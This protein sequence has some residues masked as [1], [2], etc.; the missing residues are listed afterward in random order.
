MKKDL[1]LLIG[2]G[3]LLGLA[4]ASRK[5]KASAAAPPSSPGAPG[6]APS[7][8]DD[9]E[10]SK[11]VTYR[12]YP[13]TQTGSA[14]QQPPPPG[15]V[16]VASDCSLIT[17]EDGWWNEVALPAA[18]GALNLGVDPVDAVFG[19]LPA[20][21]QVSNAATFDFRQEVENFVENI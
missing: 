1:W 20:E 21:C 13:T 2:A 8:S 16:W 3:G 17:V 10:I 18:R 9:G 6:G 12:V 4:L 14:A 11:I 15:G 5:K 7:S 19:L